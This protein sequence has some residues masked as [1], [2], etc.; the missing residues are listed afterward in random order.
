MPKTH[1]II[2]RIKERIARKQIELL[3]LRAQRSIKTRELAVMD[4]AIEGIEQGIADDLE[5]VSGAAP[6]QPRARKAPKVRASTTGTLPLTIGD[7]VGASA[8]GEARG[9]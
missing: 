1:P 7:Q 9:E 3:G 8:K 5:M 4:A 2:A 6:K